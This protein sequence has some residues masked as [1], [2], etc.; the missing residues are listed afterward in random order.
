MGELHLRRALL[1]EG[2]T[3]EEV[4]SALGRG[5]L[6]RVRP[7][8]YLDADDPRRRSAVERHRLL[9][10]ATL[11]LLGPGAVVSGPSAAVLHDLPLWGVSLRRVHVTR[12]RAGGGRS[13][14]RLRLSAAPLPDGDVTTVGRIPVT[15]VARTV[16]DM[17][18]TAPFETAVTV[19]DAAL[20]RELCTEADL[21]DAAGRATGRRGAGRARA[22]VA[23][24]DGRADGPGESRSRVRMRALGVAAPVLQHV[25]RDRS[26]R[27]VGQ[28][29]F[30]W[31]E[32]GIV[33]EFDGMEKYGRSLRPG[34]TVAEAVLREKRREDALRAQP[35]VRTVVRWTWPDIDDFDETAA[36]LPRYCAAAHG[37]RQRSP[38]R[39]SGE[40]NR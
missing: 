36:R 3:D 33:G 9:V 38:D 19:A 34:E 4:R 35:E 11:P 39:V 31:P 40:R 18:R 2:R 12:D 23:F 26:D 20:F 8:A 29:D 16:V 6:V 14:A 15:T 21:A 27:F 17:A 22:V 13:T 1:A 5:T 28:V 32:H 30:W 25:V 7:G 10:E 24:A 37:F